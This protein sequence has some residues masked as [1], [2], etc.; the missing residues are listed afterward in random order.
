MQRKIQEILPLIGL[1]LALGV[2]GTVRA[3]QLAAVDPAAAAPSVT[4]APAPEVAPT[5]SATPAAPARCWTRWSRCSATR[6]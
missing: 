5:Y 1:L 3:E 4:A 2:G 6:T